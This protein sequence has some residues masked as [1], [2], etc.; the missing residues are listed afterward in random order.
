[1]INGSP[2][3][4]FHNV[5]MQSRFPPKL[6]RPARGAATVGVD[7]GGGGALPSFRAVCR[8]FVSDVLPARAGP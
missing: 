7:Y 8:R 1:M 2:L 5:L 3:A 6:E 4:G